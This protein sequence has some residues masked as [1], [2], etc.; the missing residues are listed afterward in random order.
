MAKKFILDK[1]A[2]YRKIQE[3][4]EDHIIPEEIIE[5]YSEDAQL[6]SFGEDSWTTEELFAISRYLGCPIDDLLVFQ[7][8][9]EIDLDFDLDMGMS[10]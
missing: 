6:K 9:D 2:T 3:R 8:D 10:F 1:E 5:K 7:E 4:N